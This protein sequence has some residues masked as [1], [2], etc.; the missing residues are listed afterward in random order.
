M[1]PYSAQ[2]QSLNDI[3]GPVAGPPGTD[4]TGIIDAITGGASS[5]IQQAYL[6]KL[7][8][9]QIQTAAAEREYQHGRDTKQ[10]ERDAQK[11]KLEADKFGHQQLMDAAELTYKGFH[12]EPHNRD[13]PNIAKAMLP[14]ASNPMGGAGLPAAG[15]IGAPDKQTITQPGGH[16]DLERSVPYRTAVDRAGVAADER[17]RLQE[18]RIAAQQAGRAF[19]ADEARKRLAMSLA[20][21]N[22]KG[23][24]TSRA[25]TGN[26]IEQSAY[27]TAEG[28]I[29]RMGGYAEALDMLTNTD[30]GKALQKSGV[31]ARH[32]MY[33][34]NKRVTGETNAAV[35]METASG[36]NPEEA[37][38]QVQ[39]TR[40][41]VTGQEKLPAPVDE[42]TLSDADLWEAKVKGGMTNDQAT[43]YVKKRK[44]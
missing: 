6:R 34:E 7:Q 12:E 33:A 37:V 19:M 25:M 31:S 42:S 4:Y 38:P 35:K 26:Q 28:L 20:A 24:A 21:R 5:L 36:A 40:R 15:A 14:V 22:G 11:E 27:R 29:G 10:D 16:Y 3:G 44:Q 41:L 17:T 39:R 30:E 2:R 9:N 13:I 43:A 23:G 32:L 1:P 18:Q 8:Q